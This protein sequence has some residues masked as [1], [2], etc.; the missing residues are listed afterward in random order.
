MY[1][2]VTC[3]PQTYVSSAVPW[4]WGVTA[5]R[6]DVSACRYIDYATG[7]RFYIPLMYHDGTDQLIARLL[8]IVD[9]HGGAQNIIHFTSLPARLTRQ[10]VKSGIY[11]EN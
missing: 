2:L 10:S 4:Y 7:L 5:E 3:A 8:P 11:I 9:K 1:L 6:M